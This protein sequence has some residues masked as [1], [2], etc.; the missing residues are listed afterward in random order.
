METLP[1]ASPAPRALREHRGFVPLFL[2]HLA[3]HCAEHFVVV[4]NQHLAALRRP[5]RP[6]GLRAG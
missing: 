4:D 5:R 1:K 2:E 6:A 3:D